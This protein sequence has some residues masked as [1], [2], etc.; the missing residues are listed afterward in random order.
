MI[1]R[2]KDLTLAMFGGDR[3]AKMRGSPSM[4]L[5]AQVLRRI[6]GRMKREQDE[7]DTRRRTYPFLHRAG[8]TAAPVLWIVRTCML[9]AAISA[10]TACAPVGAATGDVRPPAPPVSAAPA[11]SPAPAA[12]SA[13]EKNGVARGLAYAE[14]TCAACHAVRAGETR[15][16]NPRAPAFQ[17]VANTPG[18]TPIALNVWLHTSHP[19]MP[20]LIIDPNRTEDVSAYIGSLKKRTD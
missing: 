20:N 11:A 7:M 18:M 17:S 14:A 12:D 16:P 13:L 10:V 6:C 15:S 2:P 9:A 1:A 5:M 3:S 4:V 8:A 19:T